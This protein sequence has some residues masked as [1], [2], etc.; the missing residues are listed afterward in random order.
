[1][2]VFEH[3]YVHVPIFV[4][5]CLFDINHFTLDT[6]V[7]YHYYFFVPVSHL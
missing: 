1:V 6:Y 5:M 2:L 4:S 7:Q 3:V